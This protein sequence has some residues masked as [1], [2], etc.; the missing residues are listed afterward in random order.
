M[1]E[2]TSL[3]SATDMTALPGT[4]RTAEHSADDELPEVVRRRDR[5]AGAIIKEGIRPR[6]AAPP[7]GE[8]RCCALGKKAE[9]ERRRRIR[10]QRRCR[11]AFV[12]AATLCAKHI[13]PRTAVGVVVHEGMDQ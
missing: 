7:P 1:S 4:I 3:R 10:R 5:G 9:R 2:C 13:V 6:E 11:G 12:D 8:K